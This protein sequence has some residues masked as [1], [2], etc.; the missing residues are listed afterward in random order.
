MADLQPL[1]R[2]VYAAR[3]IRSGERV[4]LGDVFFAMPN[5][6]GQLVSRQ[7]SKYTEFLA[8]I[9][10]ERNAPL[11]TRGL[12]VKEVRSQ[13]YQIVDRLKAILKASRVALPP[14]VDL[15]ISHHY[16]LDRFDE[17]GAVLVHIL[18]RAY[19]KVLVVMFSGQSYPRHH[20]VQKDESYHLL[21]GD[22][23]VDIGGEE[24]NLRAGDVVSINRG[25]VH[26]FKTTGG[27]VVEEIATTYVQGDSIY[28][29]EFINRN[30]NRKIFLT[31]W[32]Q[33]LES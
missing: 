10:F 21:Y 30:P 5:V 15:E 31:F 4:D 17:C 7:F 25:M 29:E 33:W 32:P 13:V 18:N 6:P 28:A 23:T 20:H 8:E 19:S 12:R 16:G 27:A 1:F 24:R 3:P 22:L 2:G 14:Y 26:S 9:D 11:M